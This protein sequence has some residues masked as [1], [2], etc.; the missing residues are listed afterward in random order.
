MPV[1]VLSRIS[2]SLA[3]VESLTCLMLMRP[4]S[5]QRKPRSRWHSTVPPRNSPPAH[6]W[7]SFSRRSRDDRRGRCA[8]R[9]PGNSGDQ[10]HTETTESMINALLLL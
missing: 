1:R 4:S 3:W 5:N 8:A 6:A 2:C 7:L 9:A 10:T